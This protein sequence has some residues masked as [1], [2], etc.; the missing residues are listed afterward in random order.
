MGIDPTVDVKLGHRPSK[1]TGGLVSE[2]DGSFTALLL[3]KRPVVTFSSAALVS[4][5]RQSS[6]MT[7]LL[8]STYSRTNLSSLISHLSRAI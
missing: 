3:M 2:T 1:G 6:S 8:L 5:P 7:G 4:A